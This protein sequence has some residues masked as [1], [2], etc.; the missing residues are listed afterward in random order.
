M[1]GGALIGL[2][3]IAFAAALRAGLPGWIGLIVAMV[4]FSN[5]SNDAVGALAA[6][7]GVWIVLRYI[8]ASRT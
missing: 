6:G 4:A 5:D 2:A 8:L 3:I 1:L 7:A